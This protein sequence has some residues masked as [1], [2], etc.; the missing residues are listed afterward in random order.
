M[1]LIFPSIGNFIIIIP[2]DSNIFPARAQPPTRW[3]IGTDDFLIIFPSSSYF[4]IIFPCFHII[5]QCFPIIFPSFSVAGTSSL[6]SQKQRLKCGTRC[7]APLG[8]WHPRPQR[9]H[10]YL[11]ET[12]KHGPMD[13]IYIQYVCI[14]T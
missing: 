12:S 10:G 2:T 1:H 11:G 4:P 6:P 5:F 7:C 9:I 3:I 14:Y 8:E 13:N